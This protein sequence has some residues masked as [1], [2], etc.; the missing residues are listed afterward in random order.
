MF[1]QRRKSSIQRNPSRFLK[2]SDSNPNYISLNKG[3]NRLS[4]DDNI[5]DYINAYK[6]PTQRPRP[7]ASDSTCCSTWR[8]IIL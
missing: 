5:E 2:N 1:K 7:S 6:M 8:C 4:P 3:L